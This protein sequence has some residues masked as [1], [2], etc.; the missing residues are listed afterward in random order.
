MRPLLFVLKLLVGLSVACGLM[1][2]AFFCIDRLPAPAPW[3]ALTG[4]VLSYAAGFVACWSIDLA[5]RQ[6]ANS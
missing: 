2:G 5:Y 6:G 4:V 3:P 1:V